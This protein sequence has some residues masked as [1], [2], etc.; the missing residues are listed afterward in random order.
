V[1]VSDEGLEGVVQPEEPCTPKK[2]HVPILWHGLPS[3]ETPTFND[4]AHDTPSAYFAQS[5]LAWQ[6][7]LSKTKSAVETAV[8]NAKDDANPYPV[9]A[10]SAVDT[11]NI[12]NDDT[13]VVVPQMPQHTLEYDERL[14]RELEESPSP[15][16][17]RRSTRLRKQPKPTCEFC[18]DPCHSFLY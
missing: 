14:A 11:N 12:D 3:P 15:T 4:K 9:P 13:K 18:I 16:T 1:N 8:E 10:R 7:S 17:T 2:K 5:E 6:A